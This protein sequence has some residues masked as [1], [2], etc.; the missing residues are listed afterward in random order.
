MVTQSVQLPDEIAERL[1]SLVKNTQRSK[2][3]YIVE[4]LE[5]FFDDLDDLAVAVARY[6]DPA[7]EWIDHEEVGRELH[8]D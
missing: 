4:A 5:Q 6:H 1:E 8:L 3:S 7:A 2:S